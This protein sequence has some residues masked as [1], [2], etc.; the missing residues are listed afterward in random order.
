[1]SLLQSTLSTLAPF[2]LY[3]NVLLLLSI[4]LYT[5]LKFN[6]I[7]GLDV[8]GSMWEKGKGGKREGGKRK[9]R[10]MKNERERDGGI[11]V[12]GSGHFF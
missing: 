7:D 4:L 10:D 3:K 11:K 6:R 9:E 5:I 8:F 12:A 1:M 2:A